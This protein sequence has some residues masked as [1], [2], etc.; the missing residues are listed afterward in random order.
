MAVFLPH[1]V[2]SELAPDLAGRCIIGIYLKIEIRVTPR[3]DGR[4][5]TITDGPMCLDNPLLLNYQ[6][7]LVTFSAVRPGS[8]RFSAGPEQHQDLASMVTLI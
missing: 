4:S 7:G 5:L 3:S 6:I 1:S 8:R 2:A